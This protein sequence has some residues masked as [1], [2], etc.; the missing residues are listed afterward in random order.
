VDHVSNLRFTYYDEDASVTTD[1][2]KV[3]AVVVSLTIEKPAG[4]EGVVSR[5]LEK[6]IQ[7]RNLYF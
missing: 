1:K 6:R 5:T 3:R 7:C 4:R 2:E